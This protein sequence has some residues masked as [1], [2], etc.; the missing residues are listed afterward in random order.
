MAKSEIS[1]KNVDESEQ[2]PPAAAGSTKADG[3]S[4]SDSSAVVTEATADVNEVIEDIHQLASASDKLSLEA[5]A[6]EFSCPDLMNLMDSRTGFLY[7][8]HGAMLKMKEEG[9]DEE[10]F[11]GASCFDFFADEKAA[12]MLSWYYSGERWN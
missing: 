10:D 7:Q 11:I 3:V 8:N 2:P 1:T 4:D 12:A 9:E 5:T 6:G